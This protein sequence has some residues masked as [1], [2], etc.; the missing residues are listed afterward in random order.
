MNVSYEP[1]ETKE[2]PPQLTEEH[3]YRKAIT[4]RPTDS[5]EAEEYFYTE[6]FEHVEHPLE[7]LLVDDDRKAVQEDDALRNEHLNESVEVMY[8]EFQGISTLERYMKIIG[9][10]NNTDADEFKRC[11]KLG[12]WDALDDAEK[13]ASIS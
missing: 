4:L 6:G 1:P 11:L 13:F 12:L 7:D 2:L 8:G 9:E 5:Y 10:A 3:P